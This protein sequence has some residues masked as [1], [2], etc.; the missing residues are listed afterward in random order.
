MGASAGQ[1]VV[2]PTPPWNWVGIM[3][4]G[5]SLSVGYDPAGSYWTS[6]T[7]LYG[8]LKL[9]FD[10]GSPLYPIEGGATVPGWYTAPLVEPIRQGP[11]CGD[12]G[13]GTPAQGYPNNLYGETGH[14]ALGDTMSALWASRGGAG[15]YTTAHS[16]VGQGAAP[17]SEIQK[18]G[19]GNSYAASI[20]EAKVWTSLAAAQGKTFGYGGV[21][22]THGESDN[23]NAAYGAGLATL[24]SNYQTDLQAITGQTQPIP[25]FAVQQS[26]FGGTNSS[27]LALLAASLAHPT[28][29]Y[30]IGPGNP[31]Q[32]AQDGLHKPGQGYDRLFEKYAEVADLVD[33]QGVAWK[34]LEPTAVTRSGATITVQFAVPYLPLV[35]DPNVPKPHLL[36]NTA[37]SNGYGLEVLDSTSAQL[38]IAAPPTAVGS[39][40]QFTLSATPTNL[41]LTVSYAVTQDSTGTNGGSPFGFIGILRD[42]DP[43]LGSDAE[44]ISIH[45]TNGSA[46]ITPTTTGGFFRRTRYDYVS[47]S[48]VT[49]GTAV[50]A[51]DF[52]EQPAQLT[53][54][55]AWTGATGTYTWNF[56]HDE[57]NWCVHFSWPGVT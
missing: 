35:F 8:N 45:A 29:I 11:A 36:F 16:V 24:Q 43:F 48:G 3:G 19:S 46:V 44:A 17:L 54:N 12:G 9:L 5:Q 2:Q 22:L 13:C 25:L 52:W 38:T 32:Y 55:N 57:H 41:P 1:C 50:N 33:N 40:V 34:P 51:A 7:E 53:L 56:A 18:N 10:G 37:W 4:T 14:C 21:F 23:G 6:T 30:L 27:A 31:A 26:T 15:S 47:G 28:S 20:T 39:T 49:S 42:S